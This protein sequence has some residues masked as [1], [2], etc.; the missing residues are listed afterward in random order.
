MSIEAR[1]DAVVKILCDVDATDEQIMD[2]F[3][4]VK[5]ANAEFKMYGQP[6]EVCENMNL[7]LEH[8]RVAFEESRQINSWD[9]AKRVVARYVYLCPYELRTAYT[10]MH[11]SLMKPVCRLLWQ[12]I[13]QFAADPDQ[14]WSEMCE[15]MRKEI[16]EDYLKKCHNIVRGKNGE[17]CSTG[18]A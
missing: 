11:S 13:R 15:Q 3:E 6:P 4:Y 14:P 18:Q 8:W 12:K 5:A 16:L 10:R 7:H 17:T 9:D 1:D 2:C